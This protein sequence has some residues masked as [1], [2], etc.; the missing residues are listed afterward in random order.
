MLLSQ[1]LTPARPEDGVDVAVRRF[2]CA[3]AAA[4]GV[5]LLWSLA[6]YHVGWVAVTIVCLVAIVSA[7][8]PA[9]GLLVLAGL[10][11]VA[12]MLAVVL[13]ADRADMRYTEAIALAFMVGAA[14]RLTFSARGPAITTRVA[15]P[16]VI[17]IAAAVASAI[18]QWT[19]LQL[20][21]EQ[22]AAR[23]LPAWLATRYLV[24][25]NTIAVA[26]QFAEGLFLFLVAAAVSLRHPDY[27]DRLLR[28]MVAGA[29]GAAALNIVRLVVAAMR[30]ENAGGV[31]LDLLVHQ[32]VSAQLSDRNA[33]GSYFAMM[34]FVAIALVA[35]KQFVHIL[36]VVAIAAALWVAG[37]RTAIAA[38]VVAAVGYGLLA[39]PRQ[40][41]RRKIVVVAAA[42]A[43]VAACV[44]GWMWYPEGRNDPAA[45]SINTRLILWKAGLRM[46]WTEPFFG[47]GLGR[48]FYVIHDYAAAFLD[49]IW[50][51]R[52]NAHN[53]FVQ[54]LAE[55]GIP[56]LLLFLAVLA[57]SLRQAWS[58]S[59]TSRLVATGIVA[60]LLTC[61][62]GHPFL[63]PQV[64]Y[65]FWI[66]LALAATSGHAGPDAGWP[67]R[68]IRIVAACLIVVFVITIP[69][70]ARD[71]R[72]HADLALVVTGLSEWQREPDGIRYRWAG[73][74][75]TFFYSSASS[76][77]RIP[78]RPGPDAP[79]SFEV[80]IFLEGQEANRVR[81]QAG[82]GWR[83]IRLVRKRQSGDND[84]FRVD[85]VA[86]EPGG[87]AP[88]ETTGRQVLMVGMPEMMWRQ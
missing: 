76:A 14:A 75:S 62:T 78:L 2:G 46:M 18:V 55:L 38:A 32:R 77:I 79:S 64:T 30:H 72:R 73:G 9:D 82:E 60:F 65:P 49:S 6:P 1:T 59:R 22:T 7:W 84:Y 27:R 51:P 57:G 8:R 19:P 33:A 70:R 21:E 87:A 68:A 3:A 86:S 88:L 28:M 47:I 85:L 34:L 11:P 13:R 45:Y 58:D 16:A 20:A 71:A 12:T 24:S 23:T 67:R 37:S 52:E 39:V 25:Q 53:Y 17:L 74:H 56:G 36:S 15:A 50:R 40:S 54:I 81:L 42:A 69:A 43:F 35:R 29:T 44:A 10:G 31:F 26:I 48:Y 63:V 66:A 5:L 41:P 80:R 4:L 83:D 61:L